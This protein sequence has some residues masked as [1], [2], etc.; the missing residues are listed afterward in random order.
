[1]KQDSDQTAKRNTKEEILNACIDLFSEQ[2]FS[3]VSIRDI[4]RRVGV[5]EST[6]YNHYKNKDELLEV[7]IELFRQE[8]GRAFAVGE[9]EMARQLAGASPE[10]FLHHHV[11]GL[12][13]RLSDR[14]VKIWRII[15]MELFRNARI[16]SFYSN[17]ALRASARFYEKAFGLM[18][19][20]G[21]IR[22][23]DPMV[24]ADEFNYTVVG[25]QL[26]N[27]LLQA[28]GKDTAENS[29]RFFTHIK[30]VCDAIS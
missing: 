19:E 6:L 27:L 28:D 10:A 22:Q 9:A 13:D 5:N 11:L 12:R 25:L 2:G 17:E 16:R 21:M 14:V 7:I 4:T 8:F 3:A 18:M 1:M 30:F 24:L 20:K 26:E 15:Y 23:G 29:A